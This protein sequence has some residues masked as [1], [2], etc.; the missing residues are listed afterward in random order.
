MPHDGCWQEISAS[1]PHFWGE[2][3]YG[4]PRL[5]ASP[6]AGRFGSSPAAVCARFQGRESKAAEGPE[7]RDER[8]RLPAYSQPEEGVKA[9]P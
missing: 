5:P 8:P 9:P 7:C 3:P 2:A 1:T 4:T 6:G